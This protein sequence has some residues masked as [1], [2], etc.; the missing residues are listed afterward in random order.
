MLFNF[1]SDYSM[2]FG[3]K[4]GLIFLFFEEQ[5]VPVKSTIF[6]RIG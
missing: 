4:N 2:T 6:P 5:S 3:L 1:L